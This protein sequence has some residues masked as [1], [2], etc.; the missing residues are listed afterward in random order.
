MRIT[1]GIE[2]QAGSFRLRSWSFLRPEF[3]IDLSLLT[4]IYLFIFRVKINTIRWW[5]SEGQDWTMK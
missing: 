3:D 2:P 4:A 1:Q 5:S